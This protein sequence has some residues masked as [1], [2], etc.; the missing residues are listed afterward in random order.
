MQLTEQALQS[1]N[2]VS[3]RIALASALGRSEQWI[4]KLLKVNKENG[5]LTT[6]T[7]IQVIRER[8]G[9]KQSEILTK[10]SEPKPATS[11]DEK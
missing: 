3:N 8:T 11:C 4:S 5:P 10:V 2:T 1:L 9:L 6:V 7:A